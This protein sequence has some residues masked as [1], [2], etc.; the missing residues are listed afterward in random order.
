MRFQELQKT[1]NHPD[2]QGSQ[3]KASVRHLRYSRLRDLEPGRVVVKLSF[4]DNVVFVV[5][6]R[7]TAFS[8]ST[9]FKS[10]HFGDRFRID[11]FS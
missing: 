10:F 7:K 1:K 6:I 5:H 2:Q 4:S 3:L 8:N 9:V 11:P